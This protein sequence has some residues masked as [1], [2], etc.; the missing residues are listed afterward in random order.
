MQNVSQILP[1]SVHERSLP[2][3]AMLYGISDIEKLMQNVSWILPK[4]VHRD[5]YLKGAL[6]AH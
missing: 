2:K 6:L 1:K 3:G 4:S 5:P